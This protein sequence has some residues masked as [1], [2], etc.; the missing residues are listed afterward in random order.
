MPE[1]GKHSGVLDLSTADAHG[2]QGDVE[3][4]RHDRSRGDPWRPSTN[5]RFEKLETEVGSPGDVAV[6]DSGT[7]NCGIGVTY[8]GE[9]LGPSRRVRE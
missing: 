6:S 8:A 2:V 9:E 5:K 1:V 7:S 4:T 3:L